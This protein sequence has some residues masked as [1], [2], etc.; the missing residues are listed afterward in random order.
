M[1]GRCAGWTSSAVS[2]V[3]GASSRSIARVV[4]DHDLAD[5]VGVD[6]RRRDDVD[7]AL[8]I[9]AEVEEDAVVAELE[10][11]VDERDL[12]AELAMQGDRRVDRDRRR[13]DAALGAVER[14]RSDR[15]AAGPSSA[16]RGANRA[17][18]LLIRASSSAGGTA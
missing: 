17:S 6:R 7:D 15:A 9:E 11:G 8:A 4:L 13:A 10:V 18:R 12:A 16:S 3:G 5:E 1:I 14:E 2:G